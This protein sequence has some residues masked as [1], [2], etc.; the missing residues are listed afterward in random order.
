MTVDV[1]RGTDLPELELAEGHAAAPS[2]RPFRVLRDR[3]VRN[4]N[5][6][7]NRQ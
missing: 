2:A 6:R 1:N 4:A 7:S 5:S 3:S